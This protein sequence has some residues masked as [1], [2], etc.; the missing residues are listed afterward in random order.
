MLKWFVNVHVLIV[1]NAH[2]IEI[3]YAIQIQ[4]QEKGSKN[5]TNLDSKSFNNNFFVFLV[6]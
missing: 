1:V 4:N 6:Y 5:W 2:F 3:I